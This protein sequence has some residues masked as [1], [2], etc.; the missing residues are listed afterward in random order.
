MLLSSKSLVVIKVV[1]VDSVGG[2]SGTLMYLYY[3]KRVYEFYVKLHGKAV[4]NLYPVVT[5]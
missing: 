4:S 2:T 3:T 5:K 1:S